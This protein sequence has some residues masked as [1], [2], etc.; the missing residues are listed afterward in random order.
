MRE[1]ANRSLS[2]KIWNVTDLNYE[3]K[4]N[5]EQ[6]FLNI[7]VCGEISNFVHHGSGHMYM[8]LKD[9]NS[10]IRLVIFAGVNT[11]LKFS[12]KNGLEVIVSG[13][14]TVY[15]KS[16]QYQIIAQHVEPKGRGALQLAFEQLK[17]KLSKEGLFDSKNKKEL[18]PYPKSIGVIT[19]PT[20]AAIRDILHVLKRRYPLAKIYIFPVKVQGSDAA[21]E[22]VTAIDQSQSP[23]S[24][25]L[26]LI[27]L[28]RGGGSIEDLWPFNEEIVAR[29]IHKATTPIISAVGHE[30]DFS[31]SDFVA[32]VRAPTPSAAAEIAVPDQTTLQ[33]YL[34][35]TEKRMAHTIFHSLNTQ[36]QK[37]QKLSH[38]YT[39]RHSLNLVPYFQQEL[40]Q[41]N[42]RFKNA[43]LSKKQKNLD[44]FSFLIKTLKSLSSFQRLDW[45]KERFTKV[46]EHFIKVFLH[47]FKEKRSE[48]LKHTNHMNML[49]PLNVLER[50]YSLTFD[51]ESQNVIKSVTCVCEKMLMKTRL[52]DGHVISS[53]KSFTPYSDSS[54]D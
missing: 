37:L 11:R 26:D 7:F 45:Q 13:S 3:I 40:S 48:L 21:K 5:L 15:P 44:H 10:Q 49:S 12:L 34:S 23:L 16:G 41:L 36:K 32:D 6:K 47:F 14:L 19:S 38:G 24:P 53:V 28:G 51:P 2:E 22:I 50:G 43:F 31:I 46:E 1:L 4:S 20:G 18:P 35:E 42:E 52:K 27:I 29:S 33:N 9:K 17:E 30:I 25:Q 54:E 39:L 8:T